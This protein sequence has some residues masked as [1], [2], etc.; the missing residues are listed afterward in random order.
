VTFSGVY[1][2]ALVIDD[3]GRVLATNDDQIPTVEVDTDL[4]SS[5]SSFNTDYYW[6]LKVSNRLYSWHTC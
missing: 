3:N 4:F 2:A 1:L 5:L 6:L